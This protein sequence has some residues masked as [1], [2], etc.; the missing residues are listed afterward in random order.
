MYSLDTD[1]SVQV[2][3]WS[4]SMQMYMIC[5]DPFSQPDE[6][7]IVTEDD[8][9]ASSDGQKTLLLRLK[10]CTGNIIIFTGN[11][12]VANC[13]S[14]A[15]TQAQIALSIDPEFKNYRNRTIR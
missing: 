7:H 8:L 5:G 4:D 6:K 12:P 10:N 11:H 1:S 14:T 13:D 15:L 9:I 3:Y 2:D